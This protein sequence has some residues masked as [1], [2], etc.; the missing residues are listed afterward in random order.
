MKDK[1]IKITK[2]EYDEKGGMENSKLFRLQWGDTENQWNYYKLAESTSPLLDMISS[3]VE[4]NHDEAEAHLSGYLTEKTQSLLSEARTMDNDEFITR[5]RERMQS[6][7]SKDDALLNAIS[8][9]RT[10]KWK[11]IDAENRHMVAVDYNVG[12]AKIFAVLKHDIN[13][14]NIKKKKGEHVLHMEFPITINRKILQ[15][16]ELV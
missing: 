13:D 16:I 14:Y 9:G 4:G 8:H 1:K 15:N 2:K 11:N 10:F 7:K 5:S 12:N 3:I 6:E